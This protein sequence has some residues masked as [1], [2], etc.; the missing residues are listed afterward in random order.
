MPLQTRCRCSGQP[1]QTQVLI[2]DAAS[3]SA[4]SISG[5]TCRSRLF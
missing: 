4:S 3:A 1:I 5:V 2:A